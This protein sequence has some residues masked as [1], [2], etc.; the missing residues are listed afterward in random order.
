MELVFAAEEALRLIAEY[1]P[2]DP[3]F[4]EVVPRAGVGYGCSEA[5]RGI[6]WHRYELDDEG[7]ILDAKIIPPTS[8]NQATI[9]SDLRGVVER[10]RRPPGRPALSPLRAVDPQ[11]RPLHLLRDPFPRAGGGPRVTVIGLGN[12]WRGDDGVGLEVARRVRGR[13]LEGEPLALVDVVDGEDDV[14]L[15]D[16]VSSDAA[17]GTIFRFEAGDEPLP[18]PLFGA[19]ST[20]ALG[21]A[22]A[23]ELARSLGRLPQRVVVY[24]IEGE[25]FAF[26][27]GLSAAVA[28]AADR[29]TEE[30]LACTRS[31]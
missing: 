24:G 13:V 8:Q 23:V 7:T 6:C 18:T 16:A 25:S 11:L 14:V 10:L 12:E 1:E 29:V 4:V 5:P 22:D 28:A 17:P 26:G 3:P 21:L 31:I 19:S 15:V 2:P 27:K 30:V 9:E 20:H